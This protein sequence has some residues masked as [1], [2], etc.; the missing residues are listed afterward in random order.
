MNNLSRVAS[1]APTLPPLAGIPWAQ[2]PP[3]VRD[4]PHTPDIGPNPFDVSAGPPAGKH[5]QAAGPPAEFNHAIQ[6][7]NTIKLRFAQEPETY[8]QFL[9]ILQK[10]QKEQR[11]YQEV[12]AIYHS[13]VDAALTFK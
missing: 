3:M 8:K 1:G 5:A 6:F 13:V 9:E 12:G 11:P 7:V 2:G 10:Y 4:P